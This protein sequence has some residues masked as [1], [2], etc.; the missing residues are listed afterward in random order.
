MQ[1]VE[2]D[3][4]NVTAWLWLSGVVDSL[5]DQEICLENVLALDPA[6]QAARQGLDWVQRQ[7]QN[8]AGTFT[9]ARKP[10]SPAAAVLREDFA[11][12]QPPPEPEPEPPPVPVRDEFGDEY[13]CPYCAARTAAEDRTCAGCGNPLWIRTRRREERSPWLWIALTLQTSNTL[14]PVFIPVLLLSY[15]AYRAGI[16]DPFALMPAYLGLSSNLPSRAVAAAFDWV[17]P[18]YILPFVLYIVMSLAVVIGLYL[19]W[20]PVFYLFL[21]N[22]LLSLASAIAGMVISL[23]LPGDGPIL[24]AR[25]GIF[26][27]GGALIWA[28]F[29]LLMVL[30]IEDDFFLDEKRLLLRRDRDA[31]NGPALL[32]SGRRYAKQKMWA[33]AVI[34]LRNA[35]VLMPHQIECHLALA[36]AHI[37]LKRYEL[38]ASALEVARRI[39]PDDARLHQLEEILAGRRGVDT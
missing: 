22:G 6:N 23:G 7:K 38:A 16:E 3:Q 29:M 37:N 1:V 14:W 25:V 17:P 8:Q 28:L 31:T 15:A 39:A 5:E 26:C 35:A 34:H 10:A 33:M 27:S 36:A 32:D 19:R 4:E 9:P 12:Q 11:R 18:L 13:Q 30:R 21:V 24:N 20:R 2:A